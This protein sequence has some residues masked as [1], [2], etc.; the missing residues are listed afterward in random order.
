MEAYILSL[1]SG[2]VSF[3]TRL[4][5]EWGS[6]KQEAAL[7]ELIRTNDPVLVSAV[8]ALLESAGIHHHVFDQNMSVI[9]GSLGILPRRILVADEAEMAARSLLIE[10][11]LGAEL[12]AV[13]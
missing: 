3:R 5:Y 8:G 13:P 12:R 6:C 9:E 2:F 10:A 4:R 1:Q 7:R 11:G